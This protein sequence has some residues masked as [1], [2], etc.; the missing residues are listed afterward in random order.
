MTADFK[1]ERVIVLPHCT[2]PG[3]IPRD[4]IEYGAVMNLL[5]WGLGAQLVAT[6]D[7]YILLRT[8]RYFCSRLFF[9]CL[10]RDSLTRC[11]SR[12]LPYGLAHNGPTRDHL[13]KFHSPENI[14]CCVIEQS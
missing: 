4:N 11:Y 14:V 12:R 3:D 9:I 13:T 1:T 7:P 5:A 10:L 8:L 6:I 2:N